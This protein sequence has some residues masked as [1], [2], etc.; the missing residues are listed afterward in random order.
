MCDW[1]NGGA[2]QFA[3]SWKYF[4][5]R[6]ACRRHIDQQGI[7][8]PWGSAGV[9]V[10]LPVVSA[11]FIESLRCKPLTVAQASSSK[12]VMTAEKKR[13]VRHG[14]FVCMAEGCPNGDGV[15][16][17]LRM[18]RTHYCMYC[19]CRLSR[20]RVVRCT[21]IRFD[22]YRAVEFLLV[23]ETLCRCA[24][25][26]RSRQELQEVSPATSMILIFVVFSR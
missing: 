3:D 25:I 4:T 1:C 7:R 23:L 24:S 21:A 5:N 6:Q 18:R 22:A 14:R 13:R 8:Q 2:L 12:H 9:E 15:C 16:Y 11:S 17:V 10:M 26:E 19:M 20:R